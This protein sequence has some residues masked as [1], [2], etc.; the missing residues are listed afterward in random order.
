M[1][2]TEYK[3]IE[4]KVADLD[5]KGRVKF[6]FAVFDT[7]DSY[8]DITR[9]GAFDKTISENKG[10]IKHYKNHDMTKLCGVIQ[11][12]GKDNYGAF[13]VSQLMLKTDLGRNTY[14]EYIAG[15]ITEHSFGYNTIKSGQ[16]TM[17][18]KECR[19]LLEVKLWEVSSLT[20]PAANEL[21]KTIGIK[22]MEESLAAVQR[23]LNE[24]KQ[25]QLAATFFNNL[26]F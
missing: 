5:E 7:I 25:A 15:G 3:S 14:E 22:S 13:A 19:E 17:D 12:L 2:N 20:M 10:R 8:G 4:Y 6:Y 1:R 26:K 23:E 18:G 21:A 9:S 24:M 11:E 16:I